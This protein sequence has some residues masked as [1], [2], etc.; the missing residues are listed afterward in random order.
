[1]LTRLRR[2]YYGWYVVGLAFLSLFIGAGT[3]GFAFGIFLPAM[4][5]ELGWSQST[6]VVASSV[7]SITASLSGPFLGRLADKRGPR[8]ILLGCLLVMFV[9]MASAGLVQEPWQFYLTF[10]LLAGLARSGLQ[11]VVPGTMISNWFIKRRSAAY[12]I[13]AMAPPCSNVLLP[14]VIAMVVATVGWR[15]GW[16]VLGAQ[17]LVFGLL[18][19]LLIRRRRPSELGLLPDGERPGA[20]PAATAGRSSPAQASRREDWTAGEAI[21]SPAFWMVAA[22]MALV[23]LG[24]N[25]SIIFMYSYF[26]SIGISPTTAALAVSAVSGMQVLSRLV[27]WAP[28]SA[29]MPSVRWLLVIWGSLM[30]GGTLSLAL[31]RGEIWALLAAALLGTALG[32]NLVLQLQV[33]PEYFGRAELGTIIGTGSMVQGVTAASVPLLLALLLDRTGSYT[34]LFLITAGGVLSGLALHVVVGKPR[35]PRRAMAG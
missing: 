8:V 25:V 27:F 15:A 13:A 24:P 18:P 34:L 10:G 22:G 20:S 31:A 14:P 21:R 33:W 2:P 4:S 17:A 6:I 32:G 9:G 28:V 30:F 1:V 7:S 3:G 23:L 5:A 19:A 16:V 29:R 12:G 35:H 26:G 11:S